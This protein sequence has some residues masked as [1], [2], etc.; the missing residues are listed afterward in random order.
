MFQICKDLR[1][2]NEAPLF[3]TSAIDKGKYLVSLSL[4]CVT[5]KQAS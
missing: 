1:L 5:E 3:T 2:E 4:L